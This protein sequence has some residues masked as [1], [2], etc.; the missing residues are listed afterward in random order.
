MKRQNHI[1]S[2]M[3][4]NLSKIAFI[5]V[6]AFLSFLQISIAYEL[7][8]DKTEAKI[9]LNPDDTVAKAEFIMTNKGKET[10]QIDHIKTS[11][12]CTGSI[13]NNKTVKPGESTTIIGTFKKGN[14]HGLNH[15]QLMVFVKDQAEPVKTLHMIVLVPQLIDVQPPIVYWNR[16]SSKTGR[17][18]QIKLDKQYVSEI[19][20]IEYDSEML[21]VTEEENNEAN[22]DRTL[23]VLPKS[24]DK[25]LRHTI[26]IK[27]TGENG[28]TAET[29]IQVFVQP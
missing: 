17:E 23:T 6:S 5:A 21:T 24:F 25:Q 13:L 10:V 11:C 2:V 15:N 27:A 4:N 28:R 9:E 22:I 7:E 12:G 16:N 20:A 8:W 29:K 19:S 1:Y 18:V 14:R 26:L 3:L